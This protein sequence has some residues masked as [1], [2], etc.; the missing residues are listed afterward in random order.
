LADLIGV[1]PQ[2]IA[3]WESGK[4]HPRNDVTQ[5]FAKVCGVSVN[6]LLHGEEIP[7]ARVEHSGGMVAAVTRVVPFMSL[8]ETGELVKTEGVRHC[9]FPVGERSFALRIVTDSMEPEISEGYI[10]V[11]DPDVMPVDGDI[12]GVF[13]KLEGAFV[14]SRYIPINAE[15][16]LLVPA[17]RE[18]ERVV[19]NDKSNAALLGTIMEHVRIVRKRETPGG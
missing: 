18:W 12:V 7:G 3:T 15:S 19:I 10:C 17:N 5:S 14:I 4:N 9:H 1:T 6:W 2:A 16:Y 11:F 8:S 13:L